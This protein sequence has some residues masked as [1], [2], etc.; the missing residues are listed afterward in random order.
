LARPILEEFIAASGQLEVENH[1]INADRQNALAN[2]A[3]NQFPDPN[4]GSK[5]P[6]Q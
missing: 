6:G 5:L 4:C 3:L 1:K 2:R